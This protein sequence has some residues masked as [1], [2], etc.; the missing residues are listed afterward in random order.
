MNRVI[1]YCDTH[2]ALSETFLYQLHQGLKHFEP[3]ILTHELINED[4]FP[5]KGMPIHLVSRESGRQHI[6]HKMARFAYN[7]VFRGTLSSNIMDPDLV[8]RLVKEYQA[9]VLLAHFAWGGIRMM[10]AARKLGLPLVVTLHGCDVSNWLSFPRYKSNL[11]RLFEVGTAFTTSSEFLKQR[12]VAL[13]CPEE[14]ILVNHLGPARDTFSDEARK[15]PSHTATSNVTF[16]HVGRLVGKKGILHTLRAFHEAQA[17]YSRMQLRI[18]GDGPDLSPAKDLVQSLGLASQVTF[19]GAQSFAVVKEEL[20]KADAFV[21][22]C[23]TSE[24]GDIE[25]G[26]TVAIT[27][28]MAAGRPVVATTHAGIPELVED[29]VHGRIVAEQDESGMAAAMLELANDAPLRIRMGQAAR[30]EVERKG[31]FSEAAAERLDRLLLMVTQST[32]SI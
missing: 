22:H 16:L 12:V 2:V 20:R 3:V 31:F 25:G 14:K 9:S 4:V 17:Q 7:T 23:R 19:L 13:G 28:A 11:K 29:G 10:G 30:D 15:P 5:L 26:P 32:R 27:E 21:L 8:G 24:N 1:A 18:L 6:P